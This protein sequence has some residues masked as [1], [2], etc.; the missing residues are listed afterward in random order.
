VAG[1]TE[2]VT[3]SL[4]KELIRRVVLASLRAGDSPPVLRS[5]Y[6]RDVLAEMNSEHHALT[7]SLLGGERTGNGDDMPGR[8]VRHQR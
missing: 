6:F 3:A 8:F 4:I 7:R 1:D 5:D 2:G